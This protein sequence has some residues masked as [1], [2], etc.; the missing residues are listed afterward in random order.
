MSFS[1]SWTCPTE[2]GKQYN[3]VFA[4][5]NNSI[6][7]RTFNYYVLNSCGI[8]AFICFSIGGSFVERLS[9]VLNQIKSLE[10]A[11]DAEVNGERIVNDD[12]QE[13]CDDKDSED[14]NEPMAHDDDQ[15][16]C[17]EEKMEDEEVADDENGKR[18]PDEIKIRSRNEQ[19]SPCNS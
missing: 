16:K 19:K 11:S 10:F 9:T 12:N 1:C 3:C 4:E 13:E 18:I 6:A 15:V 8:F 7:I 2:V 14:D 5:S 17:D